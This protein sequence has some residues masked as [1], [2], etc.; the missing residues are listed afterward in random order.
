MR[1]SY[2]IGQRHDRVGSSFAGD[3]TALSSLYELTVARV[4]GLVIE[5][6]SSEE[7]AHSVVSDTY[8]A[9]WRN[10]STLQK[11]RHVGMEWLWE[12]ARRQASERARVLTGSGT[13][14]QSSATG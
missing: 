3:Q 5:V 9:V 7:E 6:L 1:G 10:A 8:V 4:Y 11:E 2:R 13:W 14:L 12:I